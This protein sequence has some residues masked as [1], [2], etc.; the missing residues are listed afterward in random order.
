MKITTAEEMR[1]IDRLTTEK[2]G[3]PSL[4]LMDNAGLHVANVVIRKYREAQRIVVV[5]GKG[6]TRWD[7]IVAARYL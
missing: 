4:T 1:T 6:N 5:C 2:F 7:G 3:V